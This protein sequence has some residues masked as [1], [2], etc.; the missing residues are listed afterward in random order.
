MVDGA[1]EVVEVL[2]EI[3]NLAGELRSLRRWSKTRESEVELAEGGGCGVKIA[4]DSSG[5]SEME[6]ETGDS[7]GASKMEL[8]G[9][10]RR[11][12]RSFRRWT[13]TARFFLEE[14]GD[15][16]RKRGDLRWEKGFN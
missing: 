2:L 4:G 13:S 16:E 8:A 1:A 10:V 12:R 6:M 3:C 7:L 9:G 5:A 11:G 14:T 15:G